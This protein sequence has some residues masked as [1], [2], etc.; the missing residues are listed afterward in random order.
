M[1]EVPLWVVVVSPFAG[2]AAAAATEYLR[3]RQTLVREREARREGRQAAREDARESF[4]RETLIALQDTAAKLMRS[5]ARAWHENEVEFRRFGTWGRRTLPEDVGGEQ[6]VVLVNDFQRF[7]VR[8][9]DDDLRRL[10]EQ[11]WAAGARSTVGALCEED[12]EDARSRANADW[13]RC[14]VMYQELVEEIGSRLRTL[15]TTLGKT[16]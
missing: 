3:G 9:I 5:V 12:D 2:Y 15:V 11:W 8:V 4:E 13:E 14:A 16:S 10:A 1:A 7:R 6:Q